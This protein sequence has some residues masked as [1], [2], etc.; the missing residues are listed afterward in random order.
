VGGVILFIEATK[1]AGKGNISITGQLGNVMKESV[2]AAFSWVR[3]HAEHLGIDQERSPTATSTCT[4]PRAAPRR[5]VLQRGR[6]DGHRHHKSLMTGRPVR[7]DLAMTGEIT[8]RGIVTPIGGVKEKVLAA[9]RA[10]IKHVLLP[11]RNRKDSRDLAAAQHDAGRAERRHR[12]ALVGRSRSTDSRG[13]MPRLSRFTTPNAG[14]SPRVQP[15][16]ASCRGA[17][18][19]RTMP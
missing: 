14:D 12:L 2:A 6:D 19:Q 8:L 5:T 10:G 18:F 1:Y 3:T 11:A 16:R 15:T 9:H 17:A 13:E 7:S 4:S